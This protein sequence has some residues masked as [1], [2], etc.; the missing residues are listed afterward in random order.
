VGI[1][2]ASGYIHELGM[3]YD[4][5]FFTVFSHKLGYSLPQNKDCTYIFEFKF[6]SK[7]QFIVQCEKPSITL[8]GIRNR[9]TGK[10]MDISQNKEGYNYV[11]ASECRMTILQSMI[12][13]HCPA[14]M[15][16]MVIVDA[17]FNRLKVKATAYELLSQLRQ[18]NEVH[19]LNILIRASKYIGKEMTKSME[20]YLNRYELFP[21][22]T[23]I[24]QAKNMLKIALQKAYLETKDMEGKAL[25]ELCK[26]HEYGDVLFIMKKFGNKMSVISEKHYTNY[27][28]RLLPSVE[29][30]SHQEM[31]F[32]LTSLKIEFQDLCKN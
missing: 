15:E 4:E 28:K 24:I 12:D 19:N 16:G 18:N 21:T 9:V 30:K 17:N 22:Y 20:A 26:Q 5:Y 25:G 23:K 13:S 29:A 7:S 27:I 1:A 6:P 3:T 2:D 8:I 11:Y 10:E 32:I 31:L 14:E